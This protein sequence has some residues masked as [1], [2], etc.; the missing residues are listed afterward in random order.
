M[1]SA[2]WHPGFAVDNVV[3]DS[4]DKFDRQSLDLLATKQWAVVDVLGQDTLHPETVILDCTGA[5]GEM[6][7]ACAAKFAIVNKSGGKI[8]PAIWAQRVDLI[9]AIYILHSNLQLS[10]TRLLVV[11]IGIKRTLLN[12]NYILFMFEKNEVNKATF[13]QRRKVIWNAW[14]L[15]TAN[16]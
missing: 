5:S 4:P 8:S 10:F 1:S 13:G 6:L 3:V 15:A 14:V 16:R 9:H 7:G 12:S 11:K 2:I